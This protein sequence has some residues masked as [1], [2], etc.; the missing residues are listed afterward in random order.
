MDPAGLGRAIFCGVGGLA[1]LI[2]AGWLF[3]IGATGIARAFGVHAYVIGAIIVAVGTPLP[4]LMTVLHSRLR[5]HDEVS[6]G[7]LLG[8]N[9]FNGW[10]IVGVAASLHPITSPVLE[11]APAIGFDGL[12]CCLMI[13]VGHGVIPRMRGA[14]LLAALGGFCRRLFLTVSHVRRNW[15]A[16]DARDSPGAA[17]MSVANF[18]LCR[19]TRS[20]RLNDMR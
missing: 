7:T 16:L 19:A 12:A 20:G 9:L 2:L 18:S 15:L 8:S 4:E 14:R 13:P 6:V 17:V 3:V 1:A 5:G 11:L 10:A